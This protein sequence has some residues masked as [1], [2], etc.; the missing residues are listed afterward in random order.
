[1]HPS[2]YHFAANMD[3]QGRSQMGKTSLVRSY[4]FARFRLGDSSTVAL[5]FD[6]K[7]FEQTLEYLVYLDPPYPVVVADLVSGNPLPCNWITNAYGE[8]PD[9]H[10]ARVAKAIAGTMGAKN[11]DELRNYG[12]TA[13]K[14]IR[15]CVDNRQPIQAAFDFIRPENGKLY[16]KF[17]GR[18]EREMTYWTGSAFTRL[19]HFMEHPLRQFTETPHALNLQKLVDAHGVFLCRLPLADAGYIFAGLVLSECSK[20]SG[21]LYVDC[22]E[23]QQYA[24]YDLVALLDLMAKQGVRVTLVHHALEQ[25]D[26]LRIRASVKRNCGLKVWFAGADHEER[27][28]LV[29]ELA[30]E[31]LNEERI[32]RVFSGFQT[33]YEEAP[34]ETTTYGENEFG[35]SYSEMAGTRFE[36]RQ[37]EVETSVIYHSMEEKLSR[38]AEEI[39]LEP[40]EYWIQTPDDV[41]RRR[42]PNPKRYLLPERYTLQFKEKHSYLPLPEE[43]HVRTQRKN[44]TRFPL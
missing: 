25:F 20:V 30:P 19:E 37:H 18:P 34:Y 11:L 39:K 23:A 24:N 32:K 4:R 31:Q 3:I 10:A 36:P 44:D 38:L 42:V 22:D 1:M 15:W 29:P 35:S 13:K 14:L 9:T 43:P 5:M 16:Q 27:R 8:D 17:F 33:E 2:H 7:D 21:K 40:Y 6:Q 12:T 41:H 26:D 28:R